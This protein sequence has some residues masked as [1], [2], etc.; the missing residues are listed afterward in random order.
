MPRKYTQPMK[1]KRKSPH[2]II[3]STWGQVST[4]DIHIHNYS[5]INN[6][7]SNV[8]TPTPTELRGP[9]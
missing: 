7:M 5:L 2:N 3:H 4:F 9:K 8:E 1:R 6:R